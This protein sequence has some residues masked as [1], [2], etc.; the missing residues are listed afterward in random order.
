MATAYKR[1]TRYPK[2]VTANLTVK[3]R[4]ELD[5]VAERHGMAVGWLAREAITRGLPLVKDQLRKAA[6]R[7]G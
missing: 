3:G 6:R 1:E 4:A 5:E 7:K 2:S